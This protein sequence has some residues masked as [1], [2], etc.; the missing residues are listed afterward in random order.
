MRKFFGLTS[1]IVTAGL[2]DGLIFSKPYLRFVSHSSN[3]PLSAHASGNN[4]KDL[5]KEYSKQ[6]LEENNA[7]SDPMKQFASWFQE[8]CNANVLEPNAMCLS[9]CFENKPSARMVLLKDF[10]SRGFVW[11]T[12]YN[13][14]KSHELDSNK[15]AAI[16][17]WWGDLERS[18]RIEGI[19]ERVSSEQSDSY[20][21]SRPRGSKLGAW[22]SNQSSLIS[23]R[24]EL[25]KQE[26]EIKE[27]FKNKEDIPRPEHWGGYRLIP[28]C[29]EFWKGRESR[30]HDRI[31]YKKNEHNEWELRRLQP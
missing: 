30:L 25:E 22:T 11:Y 5:R 29:I 12:N 18:I 3:S 1:L 15:H 2:C 20:F 9:T 24:E 21:S 16:T 17:F 10:D 8:A 31:V 27:L 26:S 14:R 23:S 28:T 19:V 4:I 13:S 7:H 6:G